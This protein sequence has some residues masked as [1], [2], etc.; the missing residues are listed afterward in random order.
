MTDTSS[1]LRND[2][3][4]DQQLALRTAATQLA[5]EPHVSSTTN[6]APE[7]LDNAAQHLAQLAQRA[8]TNAENRRECP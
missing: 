3:A 6:S 4:V 5:A 8:R 7:A 2:L 1:Y